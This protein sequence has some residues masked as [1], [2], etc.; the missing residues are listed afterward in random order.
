MGFLEARGQLCQGA[1]KQTWSYLRGA[2]VKG[3]TVSQGPLPEGQLC[4]ASFGSYQLSTPGGNRCVCLGREWCRIKG[5]PPH[6][7]SLATSLIAA[8]MSSPVCSSFGQCSH[9]LRSHPTD[10]FFTESV[11]QRRLTVTGLNLQSGVIE[12][13]LS[14]AHPFSLLFMWLLLQTKIIIEI[15]HL[16]FFNQSTCT[17]RGLLWAAGVA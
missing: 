11:L 8:L 17:V 14:M 6:P 3:E 4:P 1:D 12:C 13:F 9:S 2:L 16:M 15:S 7:S 10:R 5:T